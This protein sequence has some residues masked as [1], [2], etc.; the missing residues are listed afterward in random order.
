MEDATHPH[1][2]AKIKAIIDD[3][4][5]EL[6]LCGFESRDNAAALMAIQSIIRIDDP[7]LLD[8]VADFADEMRDRGEDA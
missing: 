7:D 2:N 3:A 5:A 4:I 8:Q 1:M 6:F